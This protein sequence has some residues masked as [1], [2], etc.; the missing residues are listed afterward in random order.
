MTNKTEMSRDL[1]EW[2]EENF[3]FPQP[4]SLTDEMTIDMHLMYL[5]DLIGRIERLSDEERKA[6]LGYFN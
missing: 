5:K 6:V 3:D 1:T 2:V 4:L